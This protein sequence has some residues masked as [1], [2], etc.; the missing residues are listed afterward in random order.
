MGAYFLT[1]NR[2]KRSVCIDL[3]SPEGLDVFYRLA[4]KADIVFDNFSPG[5]TE[6]L[7]YRS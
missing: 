2:N 3:K 5:V 6:R 7:G 1:L 4:E